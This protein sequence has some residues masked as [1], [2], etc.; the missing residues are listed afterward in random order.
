MDSR[1]NGKKGSPA[2][3]LIT[4]SKYLCSINKKD[5]KC[6]L[7]RRSKL[8]ERAGARTTF[9]FAMSGS[10]TPNQTRPGPIRVSLGFNLHVSTLE[11]CSVWIGETVE[12]EYHWQPCSATRLAVSC[13]ELH[14]VRYART[15]TI[16]DHKTSKPFP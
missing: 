8:V 3:L 16:I 1:F 9:S 11:Q 12:R 15:P 2:I 14:F 5:Q 7:A 10:T 13:E 4:C 6:D